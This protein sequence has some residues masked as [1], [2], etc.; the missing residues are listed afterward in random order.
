MRFN[1]C[2]TTIQVRRLIMT[3]KI[4]QKLMSY[5]VKAARELKG[6]TQDQ[7]ADA[8]G[9]KDRQSISDIENGKRALKSEELITLVEILNHDIEFFIDPFS[10]VGEAQFSW[11]AAKTVTESTL[12]GFELKVGRW[13]GLFRWL[14]ENENGYHAN[15]LKYTLWLNKKSSFEDAIIAAENLVEK[16]DLGL[17][18]AERLIE[19]I[20][21]DLDIPVLF[22]DVNEKSDGPSISGSTCHLQDMGAILINRHEPEV[23]RFYNLAHELFHVLTWD[24]DAMRPDHRESNSYEHRS[25]SN[26]I[27]QLADNFAAALLMPTISLNHFIDQNR[28]NDVDYLVAIAEKLRVS[29]EALAYRLYNLKWIKDNIKNAL[30]QQHHRT[31]L[32]GILKRFSYA[33]VY[34]LYNAI[35][36]GQLSARKAAKTMSMDLVQLSDLFTEHSLSVPFE[37]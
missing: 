9:L 13:I 2:K 34:M 25:S 30:K 3:T 27:E 24:I 8:L 18:P 21:K 7:L 32:P 16:L 4:S 26:R 10:V 1:I 36:R 14:R 22:I 28:I 33:F 23:R 6:W 15:P 29:P 31:S 20:E 37:I 19:K 35:D 5:R 12:N 17:I 11:R